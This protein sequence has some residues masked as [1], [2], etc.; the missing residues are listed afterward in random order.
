MTLSVS[1][2]DRLMTSE[3]PVLYQLSATEDGT[4]RMRPNDESGQIM[5]A[6]IESRL[7]DHRAPYRAEDEK[8]DR[9]KLAELHA[10][11][12]S[13]I[14]QGFSQ[15][16]QEWYAGLPAADQGVAGTPPSAPSPGRLASPHDQAIHGGGG[17]F[18]GVR[19]GRRLEPAGGAQGERGATARRAPRLGVHLCV[20][21]PDRERRDDGQPLRYNG[22]G[23]CDGARLRDRRQRYLLLQA[24]QD[25]TR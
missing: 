8:R 25:V 11:A 23:G 20:A 9:A 7:A 5:V 14:P 2:S 13:S 1:R 10:R 16:L 18:G 6:N 24:P 12:W 19:G 21:G 22:L 4:L 17:V 3:E 15:A